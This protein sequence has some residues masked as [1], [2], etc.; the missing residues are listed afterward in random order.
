MYC[1]ALYSAKLSILL[2]IKHIFEG[3]QQRKAFIFWA[4]WA[5]IV[6]VSCAYLS[7]L[8]VLIFSCTPIR[9]VGATHQ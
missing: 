3:T 1:L 5:L 7:T 9:K 6:A 8:M 4:S 2:Q